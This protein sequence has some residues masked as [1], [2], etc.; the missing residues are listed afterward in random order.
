MRACANTHTQLNASYVW[1]QQTSDARSV[2]G[3]ICQNLHRAPYRVASI[4]P[5]DMIGS[6]QTR[7]SAAEIDDVKK[8]FHNFVLYEDVKNQREISTSKMNSVCKSKAIINCEPGCGPRWS[9]G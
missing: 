1:L 2:L 7:F 8:A 6:Q 5:L 9:P 3:S 4:K